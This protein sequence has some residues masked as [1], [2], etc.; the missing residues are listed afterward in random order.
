[1]E[2]KDNDVLNIP[3][4]QSE[5]GVSYVKPASKGISVLYE[6]ASVFVSA[7]IIILILFMFVFRFVG[8]VGVSM[9]PTLHNGDWMA[10]SQY[11]T[12]FKNGDII[13]ST[14]PNKFNENI[15][16]RVIATGGQTVD[17]DF[18]I[19]KVFVDGEMLDEP[20]VNGET[21]DKFDVSF[22]VTVP[23]GYVFVMGD[24]RR[25][26]TDSRSSEIGLIKEEY[27]LGK[28]VYDVRAGGGFVKLK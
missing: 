25:H 4:P 22:P 14:Q 13:V 27:I 12:N 23:K 2:N 11:T 24:N 28:A 15:V 8:V 3:E 26:S 19:G 17:I 6:G 20:Y 10:V 18:N 9:L 21:V 5:D 16:K 1:M 7:V